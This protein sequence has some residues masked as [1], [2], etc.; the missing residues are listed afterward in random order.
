[1]APH[2]NAQSVGS[3]YGYHTRAIHGA[4]GD[5]AHTF[6]EFTRVKRLGHNCVHQPCS[7]EVTE[8]IR[9]AGN[10]DDRN[11]RGTRLRAESAYQLHPTQDRHPQIGRDYVGQATRL[12]QF[13][14]ILAV[15][16]FDY[17]VAIP[18]EDHPHDKACAW[19]V[20]D[21]QDGA[22]GV[23]ITIDEAAKQSQ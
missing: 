3:R 4:L 15:T 21:D 23:G 5:A 20:V 16:G 6:D 10:D 22:Q 18:L 9:F 19:V 17:L 11:R 1:M 2:A 12:N 13:E 7:R 14:R 8:G